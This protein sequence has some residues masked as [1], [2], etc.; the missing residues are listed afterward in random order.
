MENLEIDKAYKKLYRMLAKND[1]TRLF[2]HS[3]AKSEVDSLLYSVIET[4]C[5][6]EGM[7]PTG[8]NSFNYMSLLIYH[9]PSCTMV[10]RVL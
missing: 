8:S 3:M 1:M 9:C 2:S 10:H 5:V 6:W 7:M 4:K